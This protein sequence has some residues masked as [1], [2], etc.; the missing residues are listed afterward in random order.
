MKTVTLD[1]DAWAFIL[2]AIDDIADC[3]VGDNKIYKDGKTMEKYARD[4]SND[5]Y[6]QLTNKTA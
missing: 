4:L 3:Y 5:V 6:N 1:K 2:S